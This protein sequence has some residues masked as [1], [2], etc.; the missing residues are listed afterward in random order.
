MSLVRADARAIPLAAGTVQCVVTSPPYWGLRD[1]GTATWVGGD[2]AC[3]HKAPSRFDYPLK[4]SLGPTGVQ[5][6]ASNQGSGSIQQFR[7]VCGKCGAARV[8]AQLGLEATPDAYVAG[9]VAVFRQVWRVLR[10]D[11]VLFLNLGDSYA[12]NQGGQHGLNSSV[13]RTK[14]DGKSSQKSAGVPSGLK[15]KDLVGIPWRVAFALQADGWY[16]RS[17][18]IWAKPNPMPE[19]VTDRPTKSHEYVFLLTKAERYYWNADAVKEPALMTGGGEQ[20]DAHTAKRNGMIPNRVGEDSRKSTL[21][22]KLHTHRNVRS[23]WSIATQPYAGAHF[24]TMPEALARRCILAGTR[25]GARVLDPFAGSGTVP[26]CA[27]S[28]GRRGVGVDLSPPYLE[29]ARERITV[30]RGLPFDQTEAT[31]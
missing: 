15:P 5:D 8:D 4:S 20:A 28:L 19:S 24:A 17:D 9:M 31:A 13:Y 25:T 26:R 11:G 12:A 21:T 7:D 2:A 23:V 22:L 18:I 6:Q 14:V 1:Y 3:D 27:I 29:L 16:L 10:D 30:T